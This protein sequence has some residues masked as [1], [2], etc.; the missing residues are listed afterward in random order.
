MA[1][2]IGAADATE[3]ARRFPALSGA[4]VLRTRA[5]DPGRA[6]ASTAREMMQLLTVTAQVRRKHADG[7]VPRSPR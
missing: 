3:F 4:E 2:N 5:L 7:P 6:A 1:E